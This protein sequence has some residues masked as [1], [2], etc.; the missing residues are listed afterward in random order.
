[1]P[2]QVRD[3]DSPADV[4]GRAVGGAVARLA[5]LMIHVARVVVGHL[6]VSGSKGSRASER[7][8]SQRLVDGKLVRH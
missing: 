5:T 3:G 7:S 8:T 2:G 1:V 6:V 4:G